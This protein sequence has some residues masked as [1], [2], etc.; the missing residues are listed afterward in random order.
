MSAFSRIMILLLLGAMGL[1]AYA[2]SVIGWGVTGLAN[3]QTMEVIRQNCPDYYR[4][5]NGQ[6][7]GTTFRSYYLLRHQSGGGIGGGFRSGK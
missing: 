1:T 5:H 6:C 4:N 2:G 3:K 7:L